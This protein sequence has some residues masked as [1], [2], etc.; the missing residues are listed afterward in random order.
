MFPKTL[1]ISYLVGEGVMFFFS[2]DVFLTRFHHSTHIL[3]DSPIECSNCC[4]CVNTA[5]KMSTIFRF[6]FTLNLLAC[7]KT[8]IRIVVLTPCKDSF[9]TPLRFS[10]NMK[11]LIQLYLT[12]NIQPVSLLRK[13][14]LSAGALC[15]PGTN[16]G[17]RIIIHS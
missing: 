9:N 11:W 7:R 2:F 8:A 5:K 17:H 16:N 13:K 12:N 1:P 4:L 3:H 15:P 10:L 6:L 14:S